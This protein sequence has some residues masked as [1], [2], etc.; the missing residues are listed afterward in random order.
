MLTSVKTDEE[1]L[2]IASEGLAH[3]M[4]DMVLLLTIIVKNIVV[5]ILINLALFFNLAV[6]SLNQCLDFSIKKNVGFTLLP[7]TN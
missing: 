4:T 7:Y 1:Q 2:M 5:M 3:L 6:L